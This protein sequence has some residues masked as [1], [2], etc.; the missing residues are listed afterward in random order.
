MREHVLISAP[1]ASLL[2]LTVSSSDIRKVSILIMRRRIVSLVIVR[3]IA[4]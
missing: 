2:Y 1:S 3:M 4:V